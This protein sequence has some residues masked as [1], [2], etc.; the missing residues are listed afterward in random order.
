[1]AFH[2]KGNS[3]GRGHHDSPTAFSMSSQRLESPSAERNKEPIWDVLSS[4]ILPRLRNENTNNNNNNNN[5]EPW[6]ILEI[7]AGAGVHTEHL[8]S[9]I[10]DGCDYGSR[11]D[12]PPPPF[13]WYPTDPTEEALASIRSRTSSANLGTVVAP[14]EAVTLGASG[15]CRFDVILCINMIHISPWEATLGLMNMA[16]KHLKEPEQE[17]SDDG[18]GYLYCYGPY[19]HEGKV[20]PS[21]E[22]FDR[23]LKSR[24]PEW[25]VRNLRDVINAADREG[26]ELVECIDM[27]SNNNS[28]IFCRRRRRKPVRPDRKAT[29]RSNPW[30]DQF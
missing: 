9:R 5:N 30:Q 23:S 4:K 7:A 6:K 13:V 22:N 25:G 8:A 17:D 24:N 3:R 21:N 26:L 2:G 14:P 18:G 27:P 16:G 15:I 11:D 20:V 19:R 12:D 1:M 10:L 29:N 28:L